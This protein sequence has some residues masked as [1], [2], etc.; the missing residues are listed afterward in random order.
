MILSG[1]QKSTL[2]DYPGKIAAVIFTAGCNLRCGYCHNPEMVL[3]DQIVAH[4][5]SHISE[6]IFFDFLD[7]RVG[8]LDGVSICGWEPTIH[9][10]LPDF[11]RKIKEKWFSVKLDTNGRDPDMIA[12]LIGEDH[13][14]YF[15]MDIKYTWEKYSTLVWSSIDQKKYE[16]SI[17]LIMSRAKDYEFR[18][19][20]IDGVHTSEDIREMASYIAWAKIYYLQNYRSDVTLDPVFVWSSFSENE[21]ENFRKIAKKSVKKCE[22]RN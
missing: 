4:S 9:R 11:C 19:T 1:L 5:S 18:S 21:L 7:R 2:I 16:K 15:A 12:R 8:I 17:E 13:V 20:I 14:D 10:D 3:P 6:N 22:I